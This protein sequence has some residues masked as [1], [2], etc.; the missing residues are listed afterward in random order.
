MNNSYF[1]FKLVIRKFI[2]YLVINGPFGGGGGW[3]LFTL[4]TKISFVWKLST[5]GM[6]ARVVYG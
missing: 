1:G 2:D 4:H 5:T 6:G 3:W